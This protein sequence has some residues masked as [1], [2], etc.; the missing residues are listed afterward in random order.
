MERKIFCMKTALCAVLCVMLALFCAAGYCEPVPYDFTGTWTLT[1]VNESGEYRSAIERGLPDMALNLMPDGSS[2]FNS[3][4]AEE[5]EAGTWSAEGSAVTVVGQNG[6]ALVCNLTED[7]RLSAEKDG[8]LLVFSRSVSYSGTWT[9]RFGVYGGK[10][11][12]VSEMG[13][14]LTMVLQE[15]G[16]CAM[17]SLGRTVMGTWTEEE[18]GVTINAAGRPVFF[19]FEK[20]ILSSEDGGYRLCFVRD[21]GICANVAAEAFTG[22]WELI[23]AYDGDTAYTDAAIEEGITFEL[24][25]DGVVKRESKTKGYESNYLTWSIEEIDGLGTVATIREHSGDAHMDYEAYML[26]S[27]H[28]KFWNNESRY[29]LYR[30]IVE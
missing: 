17:R 12:S 24:N 2:L 7:G 1:A 25:D 15:G 23:D 30:R 5:E 8:Q 26:E 27:G 16:V 14:D 6:T 10:I 29:Q 13:N 22:K 4:L 18:G 11:F 21:I 19:A 9:L 28:I 3:V 20:G